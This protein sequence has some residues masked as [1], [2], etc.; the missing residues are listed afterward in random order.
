MSINK[1]QFLWDIPVFLRL[2]LELLCKSMHIWH[3][4]VIF[5]VYLKLDNVRKDKII[6][7]MVN[8]N[9]PVNIYHHNTRLYFMERTCLIRVN[10]SVHFVRRYQCDKE[11]HQLADVKIYFVLIITNFEFNSASP[12]LIELIIWWSYNSN[13]TK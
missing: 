3:I 1:I 4:D 5:W 9:L 10:L 12:N 13:K 7:V 11:C 6:V 2:A 8:Y